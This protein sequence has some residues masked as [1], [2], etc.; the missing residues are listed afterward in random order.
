MASRWTVVTCA[1]GFVLAGCT[2][3]PD[4]VSALPPSCPGSDLPAYAYSTANDSVVDIVGV[5]P[6][7]E[8]RALT[9]DGGSSIPSFTPDGASIVFARAAPGTPG[10]SSPPNADSVW[11]MAADASDPREL[12]R[13]P[14]VASA[15]VS[16]DGT[17]LAVIGQA[18][19]DSRRSALY[20]AGIDGSGLREIYEPPGGEGLSGDLPAWRPDG[21]EVAV[22]RT[23]GDAFALFSIAVADGSWREVTRAV[24]VSD[25]SWSVDGA[26]LSFISVSPSRGEESQY[27]VYTV[28]AAG[29][30]P[31]RVLG[32]ADTLVTAD[33]DGRRWLVQRAA[34]VDGTPRHELLLVDA[35]DTLDRMSLPTPDRFVV[36]G[37]LAPCALR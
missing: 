23:K 1:L 19:S 32:P 36:S 37:S 14:Y 2:G 30:E 3:E 10:A 8:V 31:R 5:W 33:M 27:D 26:T 20:V 4:R 22:V 17:Q 28:P 15:A 7:G 29:G 11:I 9:H 12:L 24:S 21:A 18:D 6:D 25:P 16:P 34:A 35:D 13:M